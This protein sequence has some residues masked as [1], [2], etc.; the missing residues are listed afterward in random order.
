MYSLHR[1]LPPTGL[2]E[3]HDCQHHDERALESITRHLYRHLG[4]GKRST[5][6]MNNIVSPV[7]AC[8]HSLRGVPHTH[9][10]SLPVANDGDEEAP[11]A[12]AAAAASGDADGD[13]GGVEMEKRIA[14]FHFVDLAGSERAKRTQ[15]VGQRLREGIDI[16]KGL[17]CLGNVISALGD[18]KKRGR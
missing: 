5:E 17:L 1:V 13:D 18:S 4:A 16:N 2:D 14:K 6:S 3:P 12:S 8:P 9:I 7:T 10:Q 15:A 11:A